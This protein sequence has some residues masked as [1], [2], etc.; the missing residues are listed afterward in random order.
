MSN[1]HRFQN[2]RLPTIIG[3]AGGI[4]APRLRDHT[5][6]LVVEIA[7][8]DPYRN[9]DGKTVCVVIEMLSAVLGAGDP[10]HGVDD[11]IGVTPLRAQLRAIARSPQQ[12]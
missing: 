3:V 1:F 2:E 12:K 10:G 7:E 4:G 5:S 6:L 9:V 8:Y 11:G